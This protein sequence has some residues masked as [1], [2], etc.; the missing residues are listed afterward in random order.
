LELAEEWDNVGLLVQPLSLAGCGTVVE[1]VLLCVDFTEAVVAEAHAIQCRLVVAYHPAIFGAMKRITPGAGPKQRAVCAALEA[2]VAVFSPHTA[3]DAKCGGINDYLA[4]GLGEALSC[5]PIKRSATVA[6]SGAGR[7]VVLKEPVA[8]AV[9]LERVKAMLGTH[10]RFAEAA[11]ATTSRLVS[12]VA[13]CAGSGGEL[14]RGVKNA[15]VLLTGEMPHHDVLGA[16][17]RGIH[18]VLAEHTATERGYLPILKTNLEAVLPGVNI[19]ISKA[20]HE[21]IRLA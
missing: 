12:R 15:D 2:G 19:T 17:E 14:L 16:V 3:L 20:D 18:V 11:A 5:E 21:I 9:L 8:I 6:G 1:S 4:A 10:V 13:I 7:L